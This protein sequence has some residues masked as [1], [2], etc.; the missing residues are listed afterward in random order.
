MLHQCLIQWV[1]EEVEVVPTEEQECVASNEHRG[2]R[3]TARRG[4]CPGKT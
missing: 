3:K 1:G 2:E 4:A